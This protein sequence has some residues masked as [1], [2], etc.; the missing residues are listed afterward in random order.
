MFNN[1]TFVSKNLQCGP[2]FQHAQYNA[3][4]TEKIWGQSLICRLTRSR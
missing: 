4:V 3:T 2:Q 1:H